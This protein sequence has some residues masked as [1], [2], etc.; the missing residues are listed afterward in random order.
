M[1]VKFI[2]SH[3]NEIYFSA[4]QIRCITPAPANPLLSLVV[5]TLLTQK[6]FESFEVL[7]G[8]HEVSCAVNRALE[9]KN[10]LSQ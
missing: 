10:D 9:G 7:G 3:K 6:G 8:A 1:L 2:D 4:D 5:T